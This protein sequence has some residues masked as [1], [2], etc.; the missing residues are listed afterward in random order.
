MGRVSY[1][2]KRLMNMNYGAMFKAVGEVHRRSGKNSVGIFFDM[3]GCSLKY[4]AGYMDYKVFFFENL[5]GKQ[6]AT[7]VTRGVNNAYIKKLNNSEYYH[8]F[9]NKKEFNQ[10]FKEYLNRDFLDLETASYEEFLD[11][12]EKNPTFMAKPFDGQCGKGIEKITVDNDTVKTQLYKKLKENKQLL[13]EDYVIQ[14][15]EMSRL[16][17]KSV[18]TIRM[19]TVRVNEKT[20]IVCRVIR[21]GNGDNV[22]DNYNHGGMISVVDDNGV[23]TKP[24]I[25]KAGNVYETHPVTGTEIMG[26]QIP[27]FEEAKALV[28]KMSEVFPQVGYTAWDICITEN[29]PVAIEGNELPGYDLYQSKIHLNEGNTGLKPVFDRIIK[30]E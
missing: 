7:F 3:I 10:E 17:P 21:I 13:L 22:V 8:Y 12:V 19:V 9:N 4:Q 5:S 20:T 29:G 27:M 1:Y 11:F 16:F 30:G 25:D 24:A 26:F 2:I 14:H 15:S 18:N 6:R 28:M 23:I